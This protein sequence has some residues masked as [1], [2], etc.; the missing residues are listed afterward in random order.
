LSGEPDGGLPISLADVEAARAAICG[1]LHRTPTLS[2]ATLSS[3]TGAHVL[4]KAE[5]FQRTGSFKPRGVLAKL[6]TLTAEEQRRG[7]ITASSGNHGQALAYVGRLLALDVLVLM[8]ASASRVKV[9]ATKGYG[10]TVVS[11]ADGDLDR[12]L[13][14]LVA[15]TGRVPVPAFDDLAVIAGQGTIALEL[16]E[17][18]P[19]L[20][21]LLVPTSG[22]GLLAGV[23]VAVKALRPQAR[24]VA[25]EP[26]LAPSLRAALAARKPV[27]TTPSSI[28]DAL[29]A[30]QVGAL[31]FRIA[32]QL[33][34]DVVH[35][36][37]DEIVHAMRVLYE[38][39]KLACE[40]AGAAAVAALLSGAVAL[41]R[42]ATVAAVVSGGNVDPALAATVLAA[43]G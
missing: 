2:S 4:L 33:V 32:S 37:D 40:P 9:D 7:L 28:A 22:G 35:V 43:G 36:T 39:A 29:A 38:R 14:E 41:R 18:V 23:G 5:L 24:V 21:L 20:D 31:C 1:R 10:A 11:A 27:A 19:D 15:E 16:L 42:K 34:D 8:P 26:A 30:P 12:R 6:A 3:A 25:V 13:S 17:D